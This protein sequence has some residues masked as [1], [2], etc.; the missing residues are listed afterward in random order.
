[1]AD[2]VDILKVLEVSPPVPHVSTI[3][4]VLRS[5]FTAISLR[6]SAAPIISSMDSPL[7]FNEIKKLIMSG[8]SIAPDMISCIALFI[9]S[10]LRSL[11]PITFSM[12]F[13]ILILIY[14]RNYLIAYDQ[15]H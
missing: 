10:L 8:S 4:S 11:R 3:L 2:A 15:I 6:I 14:L 5:I 7:V 12:Y 9:S 13:S 1:M